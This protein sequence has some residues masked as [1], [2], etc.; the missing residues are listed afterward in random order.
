MRK[1]FEELK[2]TGKLPSSPGVGLKIL[3]L[4]QREDLSSDELIAV[5]KTDP[6]STGRLFKRANATQVE[7]EASISIVESA[8]SKLGADGVRQVALDLSL[9]PTH[10]SGRCAA[11]DYDRY[12]AASLVRAIAARRISADMKFGTPIEAYVLG[13]LSEIGRLVLASVHPEDYALVLAKSDASSRAEQCR[14]ERE[15][16][17]IDH[18]E[19]ATFL[20]EEWGLPPLFGQALQAFE[21]NDD[22]SPDEDREAAGHARVLHGANALAE[23]Y[24]CSPANEVATWELNKH[25]LERLRKRL[26]SSV[27]AFDLF[28]DSIGDEW[29]EKGRPVDLAPRERADVLQFGNRTDSGARPFGR[30]SQRTPR[31]KDPASDG[32]ND[33]AADTL[34]ILAVDDDPFSLKLLERAVLKAGH[35]VQCASDGNQALQIALETNPHVVIA[36][37]MMPN[38]DGIDLCKALRRIDAGRDTFFILVTGR[39]DEDRVV[40]AFDAGVDDYIV[41]P[42]NPRLLLARIKGGQRVIQLKAKVESDRRLILKQVAELGTL[43]RKLDTAAHTDVLTGLPNRRYIMTQLEKAWRDAIKAKKPLSL[44]MIDID[45]FKKVN[46]VHGHD[47]GDLVLKET[48]GVLRNI[49]RQGEEPAR[50]GGEEFIVVCTGATEN[51]AAA[52]AERIRA[53]IEVNRIENPKFQGGVTVSAGVAGRTARMESIDAL[54][55]A[56]DDAVYVAKRSGRNRV[57]CAGS[58]IEGETKSA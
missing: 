55:K 56:A 3:K 36:D 47:V 42:F 52:A 27:E 58:S 45:H 44:I 17:D 39:G 16:F 2:L 34:R 23:I 6:A 22:A 57:S 37:W 19:I 12:W 51:H 53:A 5:L 25:E 48:A 24:T 11:F 14:A 33:R 49:T 50:L 54:L 21:G 18:V 8:A 35:E 28:C 15:R 40:E 20:M 4:T 46:D 43:A 10:R 31:S 1:T 26:G 41:K 38:M 29:V 7:G 30:R 32:R 9:V 13:L